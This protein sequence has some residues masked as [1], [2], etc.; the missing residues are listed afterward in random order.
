MAVWSI[1]P[2]ARKLVSEDRERSKEINFTPRAD[3]RW[4]IP[5]KAVEAS[6][7]RVERMVKIGWLALMVSAGAQGQQQEIVIGLVN[8]HV[9]PF[10][11]LVRARTTAERIYSAIGVRLKWCRAGNAPIS[12]QFDTRVP[13]DAYP[14]AM[15]YATPYASGETRI[16]LLFERLSDMGSQEIEG[17][18]LGHVMAHE[19]GHVLEASNWHSDSGVMKAHWDTRDIRDMAVRPLSFNAMDAEWIQSA[20]AAKARNERP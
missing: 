8:A 1:A 13:V 5:L 11:V 12:M 4:A 19:L 9:V 17:A 20:V 3:F 18:L 7:M 14:N 2:P 6:G 16:H 10:A 15:G